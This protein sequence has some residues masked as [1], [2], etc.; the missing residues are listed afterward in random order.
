MG[1]IMEKNSGNTDN[2]E[3]ITLEI[4]TLDL[5]IEDAELVKRINKMIA[6]GTTLQ[7]KILARANINRKYWKGEQLD[8]KKL[9]DYQAKVINNILFRNM[10]TILPIITQNTPLPTFISGNKEFDK[11]MEQLMVHRWEV[12][13]NMLSKNR[14][15]VR[16]NFLDLLGIHKYRFDE[17]TDEIVWEFVKTKNLITDEQATGFEDVSYTIEY[18]TNQTVSEII[19]KFPESKEELYKELGIKNDDDEKTNATITYVE[20]WT[21]DFV[22][23]K[24]KNIIL[25]KNKNPN[26]NWGDKSTNGEGKESIV[27]RNLWSKPRVPYTFLITFNIGESGLYS[28]TS[29][30]EQTLSLQDNVNKRK[31]QISDNADE[32]NGILVGSGDGISRTEFGKI[33]DQPNLKIWLSEGNPNNAMARIPGNPL[34][35]YVFNDL[36]HTEN[37]IDDIWGMHAITRGGSSGADTATQ[38]VLQQRQDFGRVDDIVKSYEDFNE[39]YYQ[40]TFQMMLVHFDKEHVY[41]FQDEDD[42]SVSRKDIINAYSKRVKRRINEATGKM[43]TETITGDFRPPVIMVKR[44]STLPVDEVS[45]RKE[46]LELAGANRISTLDLLEMLEVP[47]FRNKAKNVILEQIAPTKLF[48]E[49]ESGEQETPTEGAIE[50]FQRIAQGVLTPANPEVSN[51]ETAPSHLKSHDEQMASR[52]FK[53]LTPER[54]DLFKEHAQEEL[55]VVKQLMERIKNQEVPIEKNTDAVQN[56]PRR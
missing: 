1:L 16:A 10:E 23:W 15:A 37:V 7:E 26:W 20:A 40:S 36:M 53:K 12:K 49:I 33:D 25:D 34:Q 35:G 44:G 3:E 30:M 41:S 2:T 11:A 46:A 24:Y 21:P 50:D 29:F 22:V 48:P 18:I 9:K 4:P 51:P 52:E 31:R 27:K 14:S 55:A 45:K 13:D 5:D 47:N 6:S 42:L 43:E 19:E 17:E 54:Q 32:A 28:D 39:Q 38:D 56:T 8:T